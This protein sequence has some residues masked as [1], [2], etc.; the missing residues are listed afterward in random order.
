M[1]NHN[2]PVIAQ[3][4]SMHIDPV[5]QQEIVMELKEEIARLKSGERTVK[6]K[7]KD[8]QDKWV[9]KPTR[10]EGELP[11]MVQ[12]LRSGVI[13]QNA[14][15]LLCSPPYAWRTTCGWTYNSAAYSFVQ[16][17]MVVNCQKCTAPRQ[18][19]E[20]CGGVQNHTHWMKG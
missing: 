1:S 4:R 8:L 20:E 2:T 13:Y 15:Y 7:L 19:G 14:S 9:S 16:E 3:Q 11:R 12:S 18:R 6:E 5:I 10:G 17:V